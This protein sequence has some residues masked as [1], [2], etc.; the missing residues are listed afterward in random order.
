[1]GHVS[2]DFGYPWGTVRIPEGYEAV[3]VP[4]ACD[5][6][7]HFSHPFCDPSWERRVEGMG[8]QVVAG[9]LYVDGWFALV[10]VPVEREE[11]QR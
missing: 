2:V 8:G 7:D 3:E 6:D 4:A 5:A 10:A 1:M 11:G 9:P